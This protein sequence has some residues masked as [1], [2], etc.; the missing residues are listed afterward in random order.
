MKLEA[1]NT[2]IT[3]HQRPLIP[4]QRVNSCFQPSLQCAQ[5]VNVPQYQL[6]PD[7]SI[8]EVK[9]FLQEYM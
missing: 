8:H 9:S 5:G 2:F 4:I 6:S 1:L 7:I 3:S